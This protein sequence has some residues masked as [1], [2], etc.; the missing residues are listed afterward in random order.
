[1]T[2][3]DAR[4]SRGQQRFDAAAQVVHTAVEEVDRVGRHLKDNV[5]AARRP[6]PMSAC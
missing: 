3:D 5:D 4:T 6:E 1:M 2:D